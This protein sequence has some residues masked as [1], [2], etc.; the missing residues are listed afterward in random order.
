MRAATR[1]LAALV[2]LLVP[3]TAAA[4]EPWVT[5]F[6]DGVL[7]NVGAWDITTGKDG[8]LWFTESLGTFG[9][10]TPS[11]VLTDF[12]DA[13]LG[14]GPR[15]IATGADGNL[16]FA[17]SGGNGAIT[18]VTPAGEATE[19]SAGLTPGDPWDVAK[20]P[21]GNIWF[22]NR[23]PAVI[24]KIT[25]EG[26]ITEYTDGLTLLSEP[27]AITAG[28]DGNLWF[29]ETAT[30]RI[31]RI[32]TAGVIT[33]F[34]SGLSGSGEPTDIVAGSDG[35]LWFTLNADPG[36]IGRITKS[37]TVTTFTDGVTPNSAPT[38]I[39]KGA[40]GA[41][42]FT[43]S[44][45]A[46]RIGRITT[47]GDVTE[48]SGGLTSGMAPW[49]ITAGPDGNMWFTENA[50]LG[51]VARI[52]LPPVL[53]E[54]AADTL[55]TTSA[56]L[57][58][59]VR[60]N[61]QATDYSFEYGKTSAYGS[62]TPLKYLGNGYNAVTATALV[63]GLEP[64]TEYHF[65]VVAT[66]DSG[67][68]YG[69]DGVFHT[70]ALPVADQAVVEPE[71][72]TAP[73]PEPAPDFGKTVVAEPQGSVRVKPPGGEW[74]DLEPGAELP[75]GASFDARRGAVELTSVGCR[76]TRQTGTFGGGLFSLRQPR[77]ACGRVD[78]YLRGGSFR[79]C[80]RAARRSGRGSALASRSRR[81]RRLWGRDHGGRFRTHG[82]H[83]HATVRGTRWFT[84]D[85]CDGTLTR[86]TQGSVVVRDFV[87]RRSVVVR[88]GRSYLAKRPVLRRHRRR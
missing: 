21:D 25:P 88:A 86:V 12:P 52:T 75:M 39:A 11:A 76:G 71:S 19:F 13:L 45:G 6:N 37:G 4:H 59:S 44:A 3:S 18:R 67:T 57:R 34:T 50:L 73:R 17:E 40:D 62:T 28:P 49:F 48:Y 7:V 74:Q 68:S 10:I 35:A 82:R 60:P 77:A 42:W 14:G 23:S 9:R 22:V 61:S 56:R 51:R 72:D 64:A 27:S 24:G 38:G 87:R 1:T 20:G 32:T 46:G 53:R 43:E 55:A 8:N 36:G 80:G 69:P 84:V 78:V 65:R 58:G 5:E 16:W 63:E 29:T 83:S 81:V 26:V 70:L 41:L 47:T 30:G 31:G 2:A 54:L 15:G 85:R 79:S 66:N 33:E